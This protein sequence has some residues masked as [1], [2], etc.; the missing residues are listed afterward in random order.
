MYVNHICPRKPEKGNRFPGTG[1]TDSCEIPCDCWKQNSCPL[2]KQPVLLS[3]E[4]LSSFQRISLYHY[5]R[6]R[7][8]FFY[9]FISSQK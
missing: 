3:A 1:V 5:E 7:Q 4:H 9:Q 8:P 6:S 2:Q